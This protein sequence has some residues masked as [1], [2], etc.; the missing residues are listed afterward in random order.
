MIQG[1]IHLPSFVSVEDQKSII[2]AAR[3]VCKDAPL[4]RPTLPNGQPFSYRM[5]NC[6]ELGWLADF[7][8]Y[9]YESKHP[10]TGKEW[11]AIP[12]EVHKVINELRSQGMIPADFKPESCL[13]NFYLPGQGLGLHQDK[14]ERNLVAPVISISLGSTGKFE[15][16]DLDRK[17]KRDKVALHTGDVFLLSGSARL[18]YHRVN[19]LVATDSMLVRGSR[20]NLTIRQVD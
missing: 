12:P 9:R 16:G 15:V 1:A 13:V 14:T 19:K 5:T 4:F 17:T 20:L 8:G 6:G 10:A 11:P 3:E 7:K 2:C 18:A